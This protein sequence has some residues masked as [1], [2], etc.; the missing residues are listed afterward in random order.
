METIDELI[1]RVGKGLPAAAVLALKNRAALLQRMNAG[2]RR[3]HAVTQARLVKQRN[4]NLLER[5]LASSLYEAPSGGADRDARRQDPFR[6]EA[7]GTLQR[8]QD[9]VTESIRTA[10]A[11]ERARQAAEEERKRRARQ[12]AS[13]AKP[14]NAVRTRTVTR[15]PI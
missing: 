6:N 9:T 13:A 2:R 7:A 15:R 5:G 3:K 14:E 4:A 11:E 12:A 8:E 1:A 10:V